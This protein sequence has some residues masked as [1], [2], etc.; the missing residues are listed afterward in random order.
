MAAFLLLGASLPAFADSDLPERSWRDYLRKGTRRSTPEE[1]TSRIDST[2]QTNP[3]GMVDLIDSPTTNVVDYGGY[4][5]NFRLYNQGGLLSH[6]SFG[7]FR[8]LNI[9]ASWD[10]EKVIGT[11]NPRT[12]KPTLNAKFRIYDGSSV[13]PSLA[14]GYDGQGRF[15]NQATDEYNERDRGLYFAMGR[16]V[17]IPHLEAVGGVNISKFKEGEVYGSFGLWYTIEEKLALMA[18]YDNIRNGVDN[19]FN[20]GLRLFPIPSLAIDF[21]FRQIGSN[22]DKDRILRINFVGSF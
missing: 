13:F 22:K 7:V 16:E 6:I 8:R 19:R 12:N 17:F 20:A 2:E 10:N 21:A 9:G 15:F 4:R 18:E 3:E 5:I 14:I 11:E 1:K